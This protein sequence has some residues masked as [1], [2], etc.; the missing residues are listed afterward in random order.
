MF[1]LIRETRFAPTSVRAAPLSVDMVAEVRGSTRVG[2]A[3]P[4][5]G[6]LGMLDGDVTLPPSALMS[7]DDGSTSLT[8]SPR[9]R[10]PIRLVDPYLQRQANRIVGGYMRWSIPWSRSSPFLS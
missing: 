6:G 9:S 4:K 2:N 3:V 5:W 8:V 1:R 7:M 10:R